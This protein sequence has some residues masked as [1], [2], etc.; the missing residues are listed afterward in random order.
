M[1]GSDRHEADNRRPE[2]ESRHDK[3]VSRRLLHGSPGSHGHRFP[4]P[5]CGLWDIHT[6][7]PL[8][9]ASRLVTNAN[10]GFHLALTR[11]I[12]S[13]VPSRVAISRSSHA[14]SSALTSTIG[15]RTSADA[16][17]P[18]RA[19]QYLAG[20]GLGSVNSSL[21]RAATLCQH[22]AAASRSPAF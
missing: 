17:S 14:A 7:H 2:A 13:D 15:E 21:V 6:P 3:H 18:R 10:D 12:F 20:A 8:R 5:F 22:A 16:I 11:C 1:E 4:H 9:L 19:S